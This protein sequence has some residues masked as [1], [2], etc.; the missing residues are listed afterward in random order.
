MI[1]GDDQVDA[2][3]AG[4]VPAQLR[5]PSRE[6]SAGCGGRTRIDDEAA[7]AACDDRAVDGGGAGGEHAIGVGLGGRH[8]AVR[9]E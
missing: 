8:E 4:G 1:V 9:G 5:C 7:R 3:C 2:S 6:S